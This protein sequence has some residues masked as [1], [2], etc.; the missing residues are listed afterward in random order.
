M[1]AT[2]SGAVTLVDYPR[3]LVVQR[4]LPDGS[5]VLIRPIAASDRQ[6]HR[7]FVNSLSLQ[8]RYQRLMSARCLLP[9]ELRQMVEI[10]YQR[11]MALVAMAGIGGDE[12]EVGVA[13]YVRSDTDDIA[14]FAVVVADDWQRRGLGGQLVRSLMNAATAA[15]IGRLGGITL[16]TNA[17]M[18]RLAR[19]LGFEV[20]AEP[21]DW[22]VKRIDWRQPVAATVQ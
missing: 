18:L 16:A 9:G 7:R 4:Q 6:H 20:S 12:R 5:A 11:E 19:R 21:G 13:R 10:D 2:K 3:H 8:T 14:E 1:G 15:G 17:P 22:T